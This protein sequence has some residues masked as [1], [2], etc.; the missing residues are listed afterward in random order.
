LSSR[1]LGEGGFVVPPAG[2]YPA[3]TEICRKHGILVIA[4][5]IQTG[6]A[7]AGAMFASTPLGLEPD[8]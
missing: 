8:L 5:E 1:F 2:F 6:F 4:D 7:R 3:L